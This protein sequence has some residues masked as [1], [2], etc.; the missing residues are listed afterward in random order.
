MPD[1]TAYFSFNCNSGRS[2]CNNRLNDSSDIRY[3]TWNK[4]SWRRDSTCQSQFICTTIYRFA[5]HE[6]A[7]EAIHRSSTKVRS[8]VLTTDD[9]SVAASSESLLLSILSSLLIIILFS[10]VRM[11]SISQFCFAIENSEKYTFLCACVRR[12]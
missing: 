3:L 9:A 4:F 11:M 6:S 12:K 8:L 5:L 7:I 2:I 10:F 1:I